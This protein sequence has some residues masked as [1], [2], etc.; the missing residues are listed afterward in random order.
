[1]ASRITENQIPTSSRFASTTDT[2]IQSHLNEVTPKNTIQKAKWAFKLFKSWHDEW[3]IR[4][5]GPLKVIKGI[6]EFTE[7][8]LNYCLKYFFSDVRKTD[9]SRYPPS[10]LK[11]LGAMIQYNFIHNYNFN[12][13]LFKDPQFQ[14]SRMV[15][16]AEMKLSAKAGLAKPKK[17]ANNIPI[18][19]EDELWRKGIFGY[20]NPKQLQQ[21]LIY[22]LG[23]H[24]SL[25]AAQEQYDLDYGEDSQI[26]LGKDENGDFLEYTER[27]SKNKRF[28]ITNT[29]MDPK[30]TRVYAS[31]NAER[32]PL[33]L[34]KEY[35]SH[36]PEAHNQEGN[37]AFYLACIPYPRGPVWYKNT[38]LGIHSIQQTVRN[39]FLHSTSSDMF[40]TNTSLRRTAKNRLVQAGIPSEVAR[41]KT[42]RISDAADSAYIDGSLFEKQMSSAIYC[43]QSNNE[44]RSIEC[45]SGARF[46]FQ[47]CT[48]K[49]TVNECKELNDSNEK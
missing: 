28:G 49:I 17:R 12:F 27:M 41:K 13:S 11:E 44:V 2:E 6:D 3:K 8:D 18:E 45:Q 32:C 43:N 39:L 30:V 46:S 36:R 5:H 15:L 29:R 14:E 47:N 20:S 42:G 25:R 21:T 40:L 26:R 4:I 38:R 22:H 10:T 1:M 35:V 23:L 34:F 48:V 7:S 37:K 31:D 9:G 33:K 19:A 24:F 16:N